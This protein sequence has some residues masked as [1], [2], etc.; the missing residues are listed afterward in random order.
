MSAWVQPE[1]HMHR[2]RQHQS[3][4][5]HVHTTVKRSVKRALRLFFL[6]GWIQYRG[7]LISTVD[8]L[9]AFFHAH[10]IEF[11]RGQ[12]NAKRH[13]WYERDSHFHLRRQDGVVHLE[14]QHLRNRRRDVEDS[15]QHLAR[16]KLLTFN[17]QSLGKGIARLQELTEDLRSLGV[18][19]AGLQGTRWRS[20]EGRSEFP[21]RGFS[22]ATHYH[23]YSWGRP[24]T[25]AMLGVQIL[26][27]SS[28]LNHAYIH[29][30][31]DP[32]RGQLGR[33]GAVRIVGRESGT[34]MDDLFVCAYAPQETD[35]VAHRQAFFQALLE[36]IHAVPRR[37]R[38]W[39]LGDFNGHVGADL[40]STAV[41]PLAESVTTNNNGF[42]TAHVC[43]SANLALI[44]TFCGGGST[45]WTPDG[46]T[47]HCID[48]IAVPTEYKSRVQ[49]CRVNHVLGRRWQ[50][51]L[52]KDHVPVEVS[53]RLVEP[54][55][56]LPSPK[57][58]FRWNKHAVQLALEDSEVGNR[59]IKDLQ[60]AWLP[61]R[62]ALSAVATSEELEC[63][64]GQ[65][66]AVM[67]NVAVA[68]FGMR[69]QQRSL[70][71]LPSTFEILRQRRAH[72]DQLLAHFST[73]ANTAGRFVLAWTF[74]A[75]LLVAQH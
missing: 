5:H 6:Q 42:S 71:L 67:H 68:H 75:W 36:I 62:D 45:C 26:I 41:G 39:M 32:P 14:R 44:N 61:L 63:H 15:M 74:R 72:Q 25:N 4:N 21:V 24:S 12:I 31:F 55:R 53:V 48:F 38:I 1:R 73:W 33:L 70:K 60:S 43:E 59:F 50:L 10:G 22:G 27:H 29:T 58:A 37:T 9:A 47:H 28:L 40:C 17:C 19:V 7:H 69:P 51:S 3:R 57:K 30:R 52:V 8:R 18:H 66:S 16:L 54:W 13:W 20:Q 34:E 35:D 2:L 56:L 49:K 65:V 11:V 46:R 23:C 64:W